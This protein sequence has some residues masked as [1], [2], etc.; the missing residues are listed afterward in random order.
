MDLEGKIFFKVLKN[1]LF[2]STVERNLVKEI[3]LEFSL[4]KMNSV[5]LWMFLW[6]VFFFLFLVCSIKIIFLFEIYN[7]FSSSVS[8]PEIWATKF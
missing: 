1:A 4:R 3:P 8:K 2:S 5:H 7:F 6:H